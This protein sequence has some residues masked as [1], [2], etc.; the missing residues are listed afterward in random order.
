MEE[1]AAIEEARRFDGITFALGEI[2]YAPQARRT[3]TETDIRN[4]REP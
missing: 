4:R 3:E 1:A 2:V